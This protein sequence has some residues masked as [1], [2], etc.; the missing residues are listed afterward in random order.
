MTAAVTTVP[1]AGTTARRTR[2][3]AA[4]R[5]VAALLGAGGALMAAGGQ[6][7]PHETKGNVHDTLVHYLQSPLWD[8]SHLLL[9]AGTV[10]AVAGLVD[11]RR[12]GV[13]GRTRAVDR[14]LLVAIG[15]WSFAALE[16]VPHVLAQGDLDAMQHHGHTPTLDLHLKLAVLATPLFGISAVGLAIAVARAARTRPARILAGIATV[17]GLAYAAAAPQI[18][19]IGNVD[20]AVLFAGQGLVTIWLIGTAIRLAAGRRAP[21]A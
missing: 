4:T 2:A 11:A 9:L 21:D 5:R 19:L 10:V 13:L 1:A 3:T 8:V 7:H 6:L 20:L 14:W 17:G 16:L 18:E 12:T 15:C